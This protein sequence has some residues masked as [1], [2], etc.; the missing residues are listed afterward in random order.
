MGD[1]HP[2]SIAR[3]PRNP[4]SS[5][6]HS[7]PSG[8]TAAKANAHL[9]QRWYRALGNLADQQEVYAADVQD[10]TDYTHRWE[11]RRDQQLSLRHTDHPTDDSPPE[12]ADDGSLYRDELITVFLSVAVS[13]L[14]SIPP[15]RP[16]TLVLRQFEGDSFEAIERCLWLYH[17]LGTHSTTQSHRMSPTARPLGGPLMSFPQTTWCSRG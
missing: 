10:T 7:L 6:W 3:K 5:I 16:A 1:G 13:E 12:P 17:S 11:S 9:G 2:S 4:P 8:V 14:Q 15:D